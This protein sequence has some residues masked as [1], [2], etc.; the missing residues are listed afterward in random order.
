MT[1]TLFRLRRLALLVLAVMLLGALAPTVSRAQAWTQGQH[2]A[3]MAVCTAEGMQPASTSHGPADAPGPDMN[4][5]D[6]CGLCVLSA[7]R[8]VPPTRYALWQG[9][10]H[11]PPRLARVPSFHPEFVRPWAF[12]ARAP[13]ASL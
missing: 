3:W 5:L 2:P 6:H 9:Q 7:E 13:P 8:L 12:H 11:A 4:T 10:P 1:W